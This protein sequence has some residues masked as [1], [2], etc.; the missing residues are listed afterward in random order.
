MVLDNSTV[1]VADFKGYVHWLDKTTGAF[2]GRAEAGGERVSNPPVAMGNRVLVINDEGRVTRVQH[3]ADCAGVW[4][5]RVRSQK[6][7]P[8]PP[9][10]RR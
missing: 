2:A 8:A 5:P 7:A 10:R 3:V 4:P 9:K 6:A 1:A